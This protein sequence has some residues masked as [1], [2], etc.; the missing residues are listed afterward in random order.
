MRIRI[1]RKVIFDFAIWII[2]GFYVLLGHWIWFGRGIQETVLIVLMLA[3]ILIRIRLLG[4]KIYITLALLMLFSILAIV[5]T[6]KSHR[7][8]YFVEDF[9]AILSGILTFAYIISFHIYD[10]K[11]F[12]CFFNNCISVLRIYMWLNSLIILLQSVIPYFLMNKY[13]IKAV[14]NWMYEDQLT[15]FLGIN[16]TTRWNLLSCL[17]IIFMLSDA[18]RKKSKKK[19]IEVT[20]YTILSIFI[21][22]LNS[23]RAFFIVCPMYIL[24]Y[25]FGVG[26]LKNSKRL[27]YIIGTIVAGILLVVL[28]YFN[29]TLHEYVNELIDDKVAIYTSWDLSYMLGANDDRIAAVSY[30]IKYGGLFGRGIGIIPLH[31]ADSEVRFLGLNSASIFIYMFG[32]LGYLIITLYFSL[33]TSKLINSNN[34]LNNVLLMFFVWFI[35]SY[36]IPVYSNITL[37]FCSMLIV[38]L[39]YEKQQISQGGIS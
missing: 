4:K 9:K 28:Y 15:G 1:N 5:S 21:S 19:W 13:A 23:T 32:I 12:S 6:L 30:A 20:V 24:V 18:L 10:S 39:L 33:R 29:N 17:V 25:M 2:T 3:C 11:V 22:I 16:G 26:R 8:A 7:Y 36:F 14:G 34:T 27:K 35:L 38:H 31:Y 37:M